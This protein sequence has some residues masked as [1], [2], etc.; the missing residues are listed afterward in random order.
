MNVDLAD[1]DHPTWFTAAG[2][3]A[4]YLVLLALMTVLLFGVP[5]ALFYALA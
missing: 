1:Y 3:A 4:G 5:T 2:T